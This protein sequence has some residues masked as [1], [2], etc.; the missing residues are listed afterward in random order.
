M[1]HFTPART[2]L[3]IGS[4]DD[5]SVA[6][7]AQY[8]PKELPVSKPVEWHEHAD[9]VVEY[10]GRKGREISLELWFDGY[11]QK[12]SVMSQLLALDALS[13]PRDW[14]SPVGT[15][16]RPH[17]CIVVWGDQMERIACV[18]TSVD[19]KFVMWNDDGMP[20]RAVATVKV[21]EIDIAAMAK[22]ER[23]AGLNA[24]RPARRAG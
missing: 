2:K 13:S 18:I 9:M 1:S 24:K 11:E 3:R 20:V 16:R 22:A 7:D 21:K 6:I 19:T 17:R 12:R 4:L 14:D 8:N 5:Q 15:V 10:A 23:D